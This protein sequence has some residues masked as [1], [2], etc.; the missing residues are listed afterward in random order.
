MRIQEIIRRDTFPEAIIRTGFCTQRRAKTC[1]GIKREI[2]VV[3]LRH[4]YSGEEVK[5][6][7]S[8]TES[9]ATSTSLNLYIDLEDFLCNV[10]TIS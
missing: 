10:Y 4:I 7:I 1:L 6:D 8:V 3:H 9:P 5:V 2:E